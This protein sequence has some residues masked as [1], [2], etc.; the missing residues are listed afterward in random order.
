MM[1]TC[2]ALVL[3]IPA[4]ANGSANSEVAAN[5]DTTRMGNTVNNNGTNWDRNNYRAAATDD[6]DIDW[7]WLGL[8][9]L[10]GLAGLRN[11]DRER[12]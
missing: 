10:A 6:N 9:G 12:T 11:R 3:S 2:L 8:I 7:G 4:F 1:I 5:Y